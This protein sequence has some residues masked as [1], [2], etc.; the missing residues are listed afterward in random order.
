MKR[1]AP[2]PGRRTLLRTGAAGLALL[3]LPGLARAQPQPVL[4]GV[5]AEFMDRFSTADDAI[6]FGARCAVE[7]I[8][9]RGGVLG[10]RPLQ[11]VSM[12]NRSVPARGIANVQA[13]AQ[14]PDMTAFL[15]GKFS[16]VTLEQVTPAHEHRLPLLNPWSAADAIVH[17][18]REP[19]YAFRIG[20]RDSIAMEAL[21]DAMRHRGVRKAG[22][23]VPASAWGRSCQDF[24]SAYTLHEPA[25]VTLIGTEWHH[26]GSDRNID[27]AYEKLVDDGAEAVLLVANE[28]EGATLIKAVAAMEASR[29]RPLFSHWGIT[30][31][32]LPEL[33]GDALPA[34]DLVVAQSF[35][36]AHTHGEDGQRLKDA[37]MRAFAVDDALAVPSQTGIGPAYDLVRLLARAID[38]A[39]STERPAIRDALEQLGPH[40]GVVRRYAPAFAPG[41]HEALTRDDVLLCRFDARGQL[42]PAAQPASA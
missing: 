2:S 12:D 7:H 27:L 24:A 13:L 11:L 16:P 15:C 23:I 21:V 33:S 40:E 39:G 26:W 35:S 29:R 14:M 3:G 36:F 17:N 8:N 9:A 41:A 22:L 32:R 19:N 18:G 30:G 1:D 28:P 31:G 34:V 42:V 6:L 10:G 20:L 4:V 25:G 5:D 37:A 38:L